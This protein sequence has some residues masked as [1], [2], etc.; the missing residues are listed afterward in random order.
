MSQASDK[1]VIGKIGAP[2]GVKGW[3]KINSYTETPEGIFDYSPWF[4]G[5]SDE[6]SVDLWRTHG[7]GL[8][9]K[10][11]GVDSREDAESIKN[12]DISMLA[13]QL[14]ELGDDGVYWRDLTGMKVVTTQGYD[15]GVVKDVFNTGA[16]DVIQVKANLN[17]AFGQK[18]RLLPF[19]YDNVVQKV[20]K[21]AKVITVDWDPGF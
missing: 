1:V 17:D 4:I 13:S 15:L 8:V 3:V 21:D 18:E 10:I 6:Y 9:A 2:Y 12:L 20:D 16:N 5:E 19:V 14:P 7:K 11:V